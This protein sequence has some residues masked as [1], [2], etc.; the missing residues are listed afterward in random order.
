MSRELADVLARYR[1][2]MTVAGRS[3]LTL[4]IM[5]RTIADLHKFAG[6]SDIRLITKDLI[7]RYADHV[8][9][10]LQLQPRGKA[11]WMGRVK[12]FFRWAAGSGLILGDPGASLKLPLIRGRKFPPYL[13]RE[14]IAALLDGIPTD[15]PEGL[16]DRAICELL[17]STGLRSAEA[18][19]LTLSD[20]NCADGTVTVLLGKGKKDRVVPI[21]RLAL[22]WVDRY[23]QQVRGLHPGLLF[24]N[25][26][27]GQQLPRWQLKEIVLER[28]RAAGIG[29]RCLPRTFRHSFAI[30]MLEGG[31]S[32]RHI[33]A[34][35]GHVSLKTTQRYT[36]IVPTEL[37]RI[38]RAA[39]PAER[40]AGAF[41]AVDP[42]K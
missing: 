17:Y 39:H 23:L 19:R 22:H 1:A 14:E 35:M 3:A 2:E 30:H 15:T 6:A 16:R 42:I 5:D 33:Q 18:R 4:R 10:D 7:A 12:L 21:G 8:G 31:A 40:R 32:I 24:Y 11:E 27:S 25:L 41:P 28:A 36:Q 37:K 26:G 20:I 34:M 9:R 38:H 29:K 13:S